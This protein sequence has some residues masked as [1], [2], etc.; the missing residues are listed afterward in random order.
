MYSIIEKTGGGGPWAIRANADGK[1]YVRAHKDASSETA[2]IGC[3]D[4]TSYKEKFIHIALT[5]KQQELK[6]YVDG[7]LACSVKGSSNPNW[8]DE[9]ITQ[10]ENDIVMGMMAGGPNGHEYLDAWV[11]CMRVWPKCLDE[12]QIDEMVNGD[13]PVCDN[14]FKPAALPLALKSSTSWSCSVNILVI[15]AACM[16]L[17]ACKHTR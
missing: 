2:S 16:V 15:M 5:Y 11:S 14:I 1:Y 17:A 3:S 12:G 10:I 4:N 9:G 7:K 13:A 6:L 8:S